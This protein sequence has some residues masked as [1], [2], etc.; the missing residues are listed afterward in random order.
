MCAHLLYHNNE[1]LHIFLRAER[2]ESE[3]NA[4]IK[5]HGCYY[6]PK[7]LVHSLELYLETSKNVSYVHSYNTE[8]VL[9]QHALVYKLYRICT[10]VRNY[11]YTIKKYS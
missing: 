4:I 10:R 2:E 6:R 9:V 8:Y 5:Q 11:E 1:K 3:G 7:I